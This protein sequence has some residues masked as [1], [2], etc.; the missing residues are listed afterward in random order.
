M[1]IMSAYST[2]CDSCAELHRPRQIGWQWRCAIVQPQRQ[3]NRNQHQQSEAQRLVDQ[4]ERQIFRRD[5]R[6]HA[7]ADEEHGED[8]SR[9]QPV[10]QPLKQGK[11]M[12]S[13]GHGLTASVR[14]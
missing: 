4:D 10:Q 14:G 3:P 9:H 5:C 7:H 2:W 6:H 11:T 8:A 12:G 1:T 13:G